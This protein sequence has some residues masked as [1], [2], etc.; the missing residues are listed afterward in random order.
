MTPDKF[1][2]LIIDKLLNELYKLKV[3]SKLEHIQAITYHVELPPKAS[4]HNVFHVSPLK[5]TLGGVSWVG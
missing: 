2:I 3:Y 1:S 5:R 4:I